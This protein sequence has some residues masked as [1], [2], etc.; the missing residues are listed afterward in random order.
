MEIRQTEER[1]KERKER[2]VGGGLAL[3]LLEPILLLNCRL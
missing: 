1:E 2:E 3:L